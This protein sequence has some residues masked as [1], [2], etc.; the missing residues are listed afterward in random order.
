MQVPTL[1]FHPMTPQ[2][3]QEQ[4]PSLLQEFRALVL[5]VPGAAG[6]ERLLQVDLMVVGTTSNSSSIIW[7]PNY[8]LSCLPHCNFVSPGLSCAVPG[9]SSA[10]AKLCQSE[11]P[12]PRKGISGQ[13]A[14]SLKGD[15]SLIAALEFPH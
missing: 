11:F 13:P 9:S 5:P 6:P 8:L 10:P 2:V 1:C 4:V 3:S 7:H 14:E 15:G 12:P